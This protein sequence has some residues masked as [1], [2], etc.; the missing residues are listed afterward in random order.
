MPEVLGLCDVFLHYSLDF[1]RVPTRY[2]N[3]PVLKVCAS[4]TL[5]TTI[6]RKQTRVILVSDLQQGEGESGRKKS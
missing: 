2:L 1:G 3:V 6:S 4:S 5:D